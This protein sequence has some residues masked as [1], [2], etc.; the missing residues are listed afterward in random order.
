MVS[1][2][3]QHL[4]GESNETPS[5]SIVHSTTEDDGYCTVVYVNSV[6]IFQINSKEASNLYLSEKILI[7]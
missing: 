5:S 2:F 4:K 1:S 3:T 6:A 7:A